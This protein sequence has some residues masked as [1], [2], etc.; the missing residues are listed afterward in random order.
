M[1]V[2]W[3]TSILALQTCHPQNC[4]CSCFAFPCIDIDAG[5]ADTEI[6]LLVCV[7]VEV[8]DYPCLHALC[9]F[10]TVSGFTRT[11]FTYKRAQWDEK[12]WVIK[13]PHFLLI[14]PV[15]CRTTKWEK[16]V[17]AF[18]FSKKMNGFGIDQHGRYSRGFQPWEVEREQKSGLQQKFQPSGQ[19]PMHSRTPITALC[20]QTRK[21]SNHTQKAIHRFVGLLNYTSILIFFSKRMTH[22]SNVPNLPSSP[23]SFLNVHTSS[24]TVIFMTLQLHSSSTSCTMPQ[25]LECWLEEKKGLVA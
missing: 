23:S 11:L 20:S 8:G 5:I 13:W 4:L 9:I 1:D 12:F 2:T 7:F 17:Q 22:Q 16:V 10:A 21:T 14:A 15:H 25:T 18:F 19:K 6:E 24:I 3:P